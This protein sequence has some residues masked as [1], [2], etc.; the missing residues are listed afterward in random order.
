MTLIFDIHES[1]HRS[2]TQ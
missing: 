1:M 2:M